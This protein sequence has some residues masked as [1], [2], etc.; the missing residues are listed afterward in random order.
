LIFFTTLFFF[1]FYLVVQQ[2]IPAGRGAGFEATQYRVATVLG[3]VLAIILLHAISI[4]GLLK[5]LIMWLGMGMFVLGLIL[6]RSIARVTGAL[7]ILELIILFV[8]FIVIGSYIFSLLNPVIQGWH[9]MC[10]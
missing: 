5:Q 8:L 4:E 1:V 10:V 6:F 9:Q 7:M 2:A 3:L